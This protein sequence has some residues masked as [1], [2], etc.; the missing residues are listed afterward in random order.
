VLNG[1]LCLKTN[2]LGHKWWG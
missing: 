2:R 1:R